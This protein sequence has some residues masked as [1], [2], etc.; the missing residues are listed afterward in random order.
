MPRKMLDIVVYESGRNR[1]VLVEVAP[2]AGLL[3][4]LLAEAVSYNH[5]SI[6][7]GDWERLQVVFP[8]SEIE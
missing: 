4:L 7:S 2:T 8:Q 3:L 1:L 5:A 6:P